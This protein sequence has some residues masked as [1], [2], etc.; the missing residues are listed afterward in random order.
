MIVPLCLQKL[1]R[2][3]WLRDFNHILLP[4]LTMFLPVALLTAALATSA[5]ALAPGGGARTWPPQRHCH[6]TRD[7]KGWSKMKNAFIL[8]GLSNYLVV[9]LSQG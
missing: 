1:S 9:I 8:Y 5:V 6:A 3:S 4:V 7:Y 2:I